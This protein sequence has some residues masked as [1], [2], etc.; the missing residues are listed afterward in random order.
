MITVQEILLGYA[1]PAILVLAGYLGAAFLQR[2]KKLSFCSR[3][4]VG[5]SAAAAF[6]LGFCQLSGWPGWVPADTTHWILH[7]ALVSGVVGLL[8]KPMWLLWLARIVIAGVLPWLLLKPIIQYDWT[9]VVAARW[10]AAYALAMLLQMGLLDHLARKGDTACLL[11]I[12]TMVAGA[13]TLVLSLSGSLSLAKVSGI[14]AVLLLTGLL[15]SHW[16]P[17]KGFVMPLI[18]LVVMV[19]S[20]LWL[21]GLY[22][23]ELNVINASLLFCAVPFAWLGLWLRLDRRPTW[24]RLLLHALLPAVPLAIAFVR[25]LMQFMQND[26]NS[27]Y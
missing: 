16:L 2:S 12:L 17:G 26:A 11:L 7:F 4:L 21:S 3:V 13:S 25:A 1:L 8:S 15:A 14:L 20:S 23:A 9:S 22:Y 5:G 6:A 27:Y 18:P 24:Q 10:C 19:C